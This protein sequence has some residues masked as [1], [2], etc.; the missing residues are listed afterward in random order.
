MPRTSTPSRRVPTGRER[1]ADT[2]RDLETAFRISR[3]AELLPPT[4]NL[5][6]WRLAP[7]TSTGIRCRTQQTRPLPPPMRRVHRKDPCMRKGILAVATVGVVALSGLAACGKSN[8][9]NAGGG[10]SGGAKQP[11]IGVILPD[12]KTS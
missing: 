7:G 5:A 6:T 1:G 12:S 3:V 2:H 10:S 11:Y 9:N 8:N 4:T